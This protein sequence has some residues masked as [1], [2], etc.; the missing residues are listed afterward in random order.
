MRMLKEALPTRNRRWRLS[1]PHIFTVGNLPDLAQRRLRDHQIQETGS[2][3]EPLALRSCVET[4]PRQRQTSCI[5]RKCSLLF[6]GLVQPGLSRSVLSNQRQCS[7]R[8][9]RI[10]VQGCI[11]VRSAS[12]LCSQMTMHISTFA[13]CARLSPEFSSRYPFSPA[14]SEWTI[15]E[16]IV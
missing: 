13:T 1:P 14:S 9:S 7:A 5:V 4:W 2:L 12:S 6:A 3:K 16:L 10:Y 8:Q 15:A 11:P